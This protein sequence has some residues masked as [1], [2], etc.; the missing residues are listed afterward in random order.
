MNKS[1]VF[2]LLFVCLIV[3]WML[4]GMVGE[5]PE[6]KKEN[7]DKTQ[8]FAVEVSQS[9]A[10]EVP[11]SIVIQG[12]TVPERSLQV[13]A[14]TNGRIEKILV[15]EGDAVSGGDILLSINMEDRFIQL[16]QQLA[17]YEARKKNYQ[18]LSALANKQYQSESELDT[19]LA[20]LKA[21][22]A[23]IARIRSDISF[24]NPTAP[25]N[26]V[27][28]SVSAEVG[29]VVSIGDPMLELVDTSVLVVQVQVAQQ[30]INQV[31]TGLTADIALATGERVTGEVR[32]VAPHASS[33][34]RT[35]LAEIGI[36]NP[37]GQ[38][39][40]GSS[41]TVSLHVDTKQAHY[42]SPALFSLTEDGKIGLKSVNDNNQVVFHEVSLLQSDN[43]GVWVTGLPERVNLITT[44]QGFVEAGNTV[45]PVEKAAP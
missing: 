13:K 10:R 44:G 42:V 23:A 43:D 4:S 6:Q 34:S 15:E 24:V 28:Q 22:E 40:S 35:Y 5:D 18:R 3:G 20:N 33:A 9:I 8:P 41:A 17:L 37:D 12:Q 29:D 21:S 30:R 25:F 45:T 39:K 36:P 32:F 16:E 14:Q 2:A 1:S 31:K 11:V 7:T 19:A 26:G 38:L 27:V